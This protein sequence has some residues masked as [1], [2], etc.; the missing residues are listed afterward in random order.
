[1]LVCSPRLGGQLADSHTAVPQGDLG[2]LTVLS[3]EYALT[4]P[5]CV[6]TA[7]GLST[8]S[9]SVVVPGSVRNGTL[10]HAG[11]FCYE[12]EDVASFRCCFG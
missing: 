4:V 8:L 12:S 6:H 1:M 10:A 9:L 2:L 7:K 3:A 5:G 11:S